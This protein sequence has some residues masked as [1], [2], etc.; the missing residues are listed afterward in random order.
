MKQLVY[1]L[2]ANSLYI[3]IG[4]LAVVRGQIFYE[5]RQF[6]FYPPEFSWLMNSPWFDLAMVVSGILLIAYALSS[7]KSNFILGVLM[8]IIAGLIGLVA[9]IELEHCVFAGQ[10]KLA[11]NVASNLFIIAVIMWTA[12]HRSKR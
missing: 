4:I 1:R 11:Q 10:I 5:E 8:A 7:M 3:L 12:R 2:K 6:F 9:I